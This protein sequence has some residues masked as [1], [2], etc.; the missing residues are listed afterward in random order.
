LF[1]DQAERLS[2]E[3]TG[4][5][6][7]KSKRRSLIELFTT[8]KIGLRITNTG[9]GRRD[10]SVQSR[11]RKACISAYNTSDPDPTKRCLWC[12]VTKTW[13]LEDFTTAVHFFAY[14]H[15]QDIMD[16]IS[17]V[18]E[19]LELFSPLNGMIISQ[20]VEKKFDKGF[21]AIVPRLPNYPTQPQIALWNR[22][23][24]KEYKIRILDL[25]SPEVDE[26]V[27][28]GSDLTWRGLDSADVEFRSTFRSSY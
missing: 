25:T 18:T 24:P 1:R 28:L 23:E 3:T 11:F 14:I 19:N 20:I 6:I 27:G 13:L 26:V 16:S 2:T 4:R 12:P 5:E 7:E 8:S 10:T 15:G 21:I 22:S 17:G 9:R